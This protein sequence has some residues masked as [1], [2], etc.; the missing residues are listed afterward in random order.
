MKKLNMTLIL[1]ATVYNRGLNNETNVE[2]KLLINGTTV[3]NVTIPLLVNGSFYTLNYTWT[4]NIVAVYNVTAFA[5]PVPEENVTINNVA[6][7]FVHVQYPIINP[8]PGHYAYYLFKLYSPTGIP[9][10]G[11]WNFTY[12]Y[13]IERYKMHVTTW[14]K[15]PDG[16]IFQD[17]MIVNT[18]NRLIESGSNAGWWYFGWIETDIDIGS[19]INLLD[20][21]AT[22]SGTK[23][24]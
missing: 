18:M 3:S 5:P 24:L 13:Y 20:G 1:N 12:D 10:E 19:T 21:T 22:V 7:K 9:T 8:E 11:Y 14:Q 6:M 4:P 16:Y 17:W 23:V 15:T 2:L